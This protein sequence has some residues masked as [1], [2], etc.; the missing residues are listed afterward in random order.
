ME[1]LH[2]TIAMDTDF[3]NRSN[4]SQ[5]SKTEVEAE[6]TGFEDLLEVSYILDA[7]ILLL[8]VLGIVGNAMI[9][10]VAKHMVN[11]KKKAG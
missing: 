7:F 4:S 3:E 2:Q 1:S 11:I 10:L 9:L 6:E 5:V 8:C